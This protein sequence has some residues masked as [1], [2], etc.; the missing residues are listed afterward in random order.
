M[1]EKIKGII[2]SH[3]LAAQTN[4][5]GKHTVCIRVQNNS[6]NRRYS[7]GCEMSEQEWKR[8]SRFP[9]SDHPATICFNDFV[10]AVKRLV[11]ENCFSFQNLSRYMDRRGQRTIQE[12]ILQKS[13][14]MKSQNKHSSGGLYAIIAS[15]LDEYLGKDLPVTRFT[16][17]RAKAFLQWLVDERKNGPT[18]IAIKMECLN[19]VLNAAVKDRLIEAN[20]L[21]GIRKPRKNHRNL[22][23]SERS[24]ALLLSVTPEDIGEGHF[25]WLCFWRCIYY[26]NG[27]NV[28]DLLRLT[29]DNIRPDSNEIVFQRRKTR[30]SYKKETHVFLI[31]ELKESLRY[32]SGKG[33]HIIPLLDGYRPESEDEYFRVKQVTRC[34]NQHMKKICAMLGIPEKIST[35]TGRHA[36]ATR[37]MQKSVP[38]A[39]ISE[40]LGHASISTTQHYLDGYTSEQ[41]R[42]NAQLLKV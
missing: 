16:E 12:L 9:E 42:Q 38:I 15:N 26:G 24:L 6:E 7:T 3:Y 28:Q 5:N 11:S 39:F 21:A 31:D 29:P 40:A 22:A 17:D 14:E 34:I 13:G 2:L 20:P 8:Y 10:T 41:R 36:F 19:C 35:G 27:M 23:V 25:Y 18:T 37:L 32:I 4:K 1:R 30:E 33:Q